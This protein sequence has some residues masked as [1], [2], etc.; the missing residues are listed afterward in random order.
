MNPRI[1]SGV[2]N[3]VSKPP[4]FEKHLPNSATPLHRIE[5]L[6]DLWVGVLETLG[7]WL[8]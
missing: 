3:I 6:L 7:V 4:S 8:L 1:S 2:G 5:T